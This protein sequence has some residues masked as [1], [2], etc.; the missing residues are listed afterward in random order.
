MIF[1]KFER[2]R[3]NLS[4]YSLRVGERLR[5]ILNG[6]IKTW[7]YIIPEWILSYK[8]EEGLWLSHRIRTQKQN[9]FNKLWRSYSI[10]TALQTDHCHFV[11]RIKYSVI[12]ISYVTSIPIHPLPDITQFLHIDTRGKFH[13][14]AINTNALIK[15]IPVFDIST[16]R[17]TIS[18]YRDFGSTHVA[19]VNVSTSSNDDLIRSSSDES[20]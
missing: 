2:T 4:I 9:P 10:Q 16:A 20:R 1:L 19:N 13:Y 7:I 18:L 12:S 3:K 6:R 8:S 17:N 5:D 14:L 15:T 11:F